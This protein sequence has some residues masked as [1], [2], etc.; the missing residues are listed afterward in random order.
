VR[1]D[2]LLGITF[3]PGQNILGQFRIQPSRQPVNRKGGR[4]KHLHGRR[5][6]VLDGQVLISKQDRVRD[7]IKQFFVALVI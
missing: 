5:V 3:F 1:P 6:G 4:L 2:R 7:H